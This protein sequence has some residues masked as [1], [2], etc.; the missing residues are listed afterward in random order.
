MAARVNHRQ[1]RM[2]NPPVLSGHSGEY[3]LGAVSLIEE[4]LG[5]KYLGLTPSIDVT[6]F[7]QSSR[8]DYFGDTMRLIIEEAIRKRRYL[9]FTYKGIARVVQ[10]AA[11]G[12]S[13]EGNEVLRCFQTEGAHN[14]DG[15][16]WVLCTLSKISGLGVPGEKF[17]APPPG[18]NRGDKGMVKIYVEL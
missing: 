11:I 17:E 1:P 14:T 9:I 10:P 16:D 2:P 3:T 6:I 18:Y 5:D 15:H 12:V 7:R 13:R 4:M 8:Q